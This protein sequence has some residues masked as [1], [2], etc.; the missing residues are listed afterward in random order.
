MQALLIG[1]RAKILT[2]VE[3][4]LRAFG[5]QVT[6]TNDLDLQKLLAFD[7]SKITVVAFGRAVSK[8][9]KDV[10]LRHYKQQNSSVVAVDGLAPIPELI[11]YQILAAARPIT[12]QALADAKQASE[13]PLQL[14]IKA[15]RLNWLYRIKTKEVEVPLAQG[16]SAD[17]VKIFKGF[18]FLVFEMNGRYSVISN[19]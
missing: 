15:F 6:L 4:R 1:K 16:T 10:L 12:S 7:V 5:W 13:G 14:H 9:D 19:K 18:P 11:V 17:L 2:S 8:S 3:D